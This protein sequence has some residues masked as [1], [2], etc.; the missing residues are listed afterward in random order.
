MQSGNRKDILFYSNYC[1]YCNEILSQIVKKNAKQE[2]VLVC[3]DSN[4]YQLPNFVDRVPLIYTKNDEMVYDD[5]II[6]Y[7]EMLFPNETEEIL[8]WSL[9]QSANYSNQFSF[10][11]EDSADMQNKGYT[12]LGYD[13]KITT[14]VDDSDSSKKGKFDSSQMDKYMQAREADEQVF[15]KNMNGD[16][17]QNV[18]RR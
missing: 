6:K 10:L 3:V 7:L 8:P 16:G 2:F 13:Q 9:Q 12:M 4:K 17:T 14:T 11:L 18:F 5:S 1:E 15:K